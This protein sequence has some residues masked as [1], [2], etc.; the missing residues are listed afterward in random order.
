[1]SSPAIRTVLADTEKAVNNGVQFFFCNTN[2]GLNEGGVNYLEK[3]MHKKQLAAAWERF[4]Y[5]SHM[6]RVK[7]HDV[8]FMYA[9]G[10]G[11]I[12]V[13]QADGAVEK[14]EPE[15]R[16]RLCKAWSVKEWR[17]KM[18]TDWFKWL[19]DEDAIIWPSKT[20][21]RSKTFF[22]LTGDEHEDV[23]IAVGK[24]FLRVGSPV[25]A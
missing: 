8:I 6:D 21:F 25:K 19:A 14:L 12:G 24:A 17:I 7:K 23:R 5:P 3:Q 22:D 20:L 16:G 13:G 9:N 4:N 1:M 18:K 15:Q 10:V 11:F 2:R